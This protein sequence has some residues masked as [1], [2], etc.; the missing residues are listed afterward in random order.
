MTVAPGRNNNNQGYRFRERE[1]EI[2][3]RHG[4]RPVPTALETVLETV[5]Y[6]APAPAK[7]KRRT[8]ASPIDGLGLTLTLI[9]AGV[10]GIAM[11]IATTWL[12]SIQFGI[13]SMA[14]AT[15]ETYAEIEALSVK[16]ERSTSI[17]VV[18]YRAINELG[19]IYPA[20]NQVVYLEEEPVPM[21][22]F[23]QYIKENAYLIW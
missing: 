7:V 10:V 19:M 9:F 20:A 13:N 14:K 18:E 12:S 17:S 3:F 2:D 4:L 23:A 8:A 11:I 6:A 16:I 5:P 22:D 21:N 1:T 15:E